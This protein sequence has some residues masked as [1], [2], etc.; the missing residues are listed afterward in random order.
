MTHFDGYEL[1]KLLEHDTRK[2]RCDV[3]DERVV[4][5]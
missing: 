2:E 1:R 4:V 5:S 3:A